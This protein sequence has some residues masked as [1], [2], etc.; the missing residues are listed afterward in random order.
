M[1]SNGK[2][3]NL[4]SR[5]PQLIFDKIREEIYGSARALEALDELVRE[6]ADREILIG[7]LLDA[8]RPYEQSRLKALRCKWKDLEA[9]VAVLHMARERAERI[10]ADPFSNDKL[11]VG[12]FRISRAPVIHSELEALRDCAMHAQR[13]ARAQRTFLVEYQRNAYRWQIG[14][15]TEY[16]KQ[17]TGKLYYRQIADLLSTAFAAIGRQRM[18]SEDSIRKTRQNLIESIDKRP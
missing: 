3:A 1:K 15:M 5:S 18:L 17:Q 16:V 8:V 2:A 4:V 12:I 14:R 6:G 10:A 7:L 13:N 9:L 11:W